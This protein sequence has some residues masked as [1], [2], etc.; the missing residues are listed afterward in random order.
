MTHSNTR[1]HSASQFGARLIGAALIASFVACSQTPPTKTTERGGTDDP[2]DRAARYVL[3]TA[4]AFR[5]AYTQAVVEHVKK[6]GVLARE[7][8]MK[9]AHAVMLPAQFIQAAGFEIKDFELSLIGATPLY[10]ANLPKTPAEAEALKEFAAHPD[11]KILTFADGN[12]FK[13]LA[14]DFAI[15]Q[16]CAD[17]HNAHPQSPRRNFRQGDLM[18]AIIVRMPDAR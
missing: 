5:T 18:G 2:R 16:D 7:E 9:D 3:A 8:W 15:A 6:S 12:Q 17:C 14:A 13:G 1:S 11:K 10:Q 4:K